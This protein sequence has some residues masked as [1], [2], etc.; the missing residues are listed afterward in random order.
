MNAFI[1]NPDWPTR[2]AHSHHILAML[3]L[4]PR[5]KLPKEGMPPRQI[6]GFKVW[7]APLSP[8][9]DAHATYTHNGRTYRYGKRSTHRVLTE[10]PCC[11]KVLSVGRLHQHRCPFANDSEPTSL[12]SP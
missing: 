12:T 3:G 8:D 2:N 6:Q 9:Y 4:P 10:C 1:R 11:R 5:A 7:V